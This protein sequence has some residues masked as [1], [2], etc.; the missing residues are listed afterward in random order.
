[1]SRLTREAQLLRTFV[2]LA[3]TLVADYDVVD[4]LQT[5]VERSQ[6]LFDVTAACILLAD[7]DG[8][9]EL[10]AST[11]EES[12]LVET[13]QLA[14][15]A[16]PCVEAYTTGRIVTVEDIAQVPEAWSAFRDRAL[17]L[18]FRSV[19]AIPLRLRD[20]VIG[21]LNL[22]GDATGVLVGDDLEAAR[23]MADVA[24]VGIL[25][26]RMIREVDVVRE[27]LQGA[28]NS[29]IVIEQ[30]KGVV[31]HQ[32]SVQPDEAFDLIRDYARSH[33]QSLTHVATLLVRRDLTI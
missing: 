3:D 31:A 10:M 15:D 26:E 5:L 16:G 25:Q 28:L 32:R 17:E 20:D 33:R 14:A 29:R 30:A 7:G 24:T 21:T 9:L 27:Q 13:M 12:A 22:F 2:T 4:L 23:A 19:Q 18:G 6:E 1:M 8:Q 11:S